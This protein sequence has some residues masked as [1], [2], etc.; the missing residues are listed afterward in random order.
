MCTH[1]SPSQSMDAAQHMAPLLKTR[2]AVGRVVGAGGEGTRYMPL[3]TCS[4]RLD[5]RWLHASMLPRP[6]CRQFCL[7]EVA[8]AAFGSGDHGLKCTGRSLLHLRRR[9]WETRRGL[10][11]D[12][13][14]QDRETR[15][16][17]QAERQAERQAG[18]GVWDEASAHP[19]SIELH[20]PPFIPLS[21]ASI[22]GIE[23]GRI[24]QRTGNPTVEP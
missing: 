11:C 20:V 23:T 13:I 12:G 8:L 7:L 17:P 5:P 18:L 19:R 1:S 6:T 9:V 14:D 24:G 3:S 10:A 15:Q 4:P 22:G 21:A 16:V 2:R